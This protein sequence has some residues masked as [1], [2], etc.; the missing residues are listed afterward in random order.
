MSP[1]ELRR[2]SSEKKKKALTEDEWDK[3]TK[4]TL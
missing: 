3:I 4:E 1:E 2:R